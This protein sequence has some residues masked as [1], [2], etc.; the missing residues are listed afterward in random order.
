M[1]AFVYTNSCVTKLKKT[2]VQI[3]KHIDIY[4]T[5]SRGREAVHN[6]K[7]KDNQEISI[8]R[9]IKFQFKSLEDLRKSKM[10]MIKQIR[11]ID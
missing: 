2:R 5:F 11:D 1:C 9:R 6:V 3:I 4:N 7:L 8:R 10:V